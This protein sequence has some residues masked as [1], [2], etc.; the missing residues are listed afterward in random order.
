MQGLREIRQL[1]E[2]IP[3]CLSDGVHVTMVEVP[4][5]AELKEKLKRLE[6]KLENL[7]ELGVLLG[8]S[9]GCEQFEKLLGPEVEK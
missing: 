7:R 4:H 2:S 6:K 3:E 1:A 5:L 8:E 9:W